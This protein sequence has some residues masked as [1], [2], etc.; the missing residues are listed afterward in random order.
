Q[1]PPVML[2]S[3]RTATAWFRAPTVHISTT[4]EF[5]LVVSDGEASSDEARVT[6]IITP[7]ADSDNDGL[8]DEEE[9]MLGTDPHN[10][11][12][13]GDGITDGDEDT[14]KN[15]K[16]DLGE[17]DPLD[18]ASKVGCAPDLSCPSGLSCIKN[19]CRP[20]AAPDAGLMCTRLADRGTECCMGGCASG[21]L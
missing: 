19:A 2:S 4:L 11:D 17:S 9:A 8:D 12:T 15:G 16:V 10:P 14:N 18:S 21:T 3:A 6:V 20:A 5:G 7:I 1:G 13:D